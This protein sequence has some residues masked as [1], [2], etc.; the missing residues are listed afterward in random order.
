MTG[1]PLLSPAQVLVQ[2]EFR[3]RLAYIVESYRIWSTLFEAGPTINESLALLKE[4]SEDEETPP[5]NLQVEMAI[6]MLA[7]HA[8]DR[9]VLGP[10]CHPAPDELE[11][12]RQ[13]FVERMKP[14]RGRPDSRVLRYHVQG[15][16]ILWEWAT[17]AGVTA[18]P[19]TGTR[20]KPQMTSAGAKVIEQTFQSIDPSIRT[21]TLMNIVRKTRQKR[22]LAGK[23]FED[24]FPG[25]GLRVAVH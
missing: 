20:Y 5:L 24:F 2:M 13:T 10:L 17:G 3:R 14:I 25:Y 15:L 11:A 16:M 6:E 4:R 1:E 23:R 8:F 21:T 9:D 12:A 7:T 19:T 18:S 22:Q